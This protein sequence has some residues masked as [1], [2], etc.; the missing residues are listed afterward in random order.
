M[1]VSTDEEVRVYEEE[2]KR[3]NSTLVGINSEISELNT[4][5]DSIAKELER[6]EADLQQIE[7]EFSRTSEIYNQRVVLMYKFSRSGLFNTVFD[8][9]CLNQFYGRLKMFHLL[10]TMD[11]RAF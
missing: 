1:S 9:E 5:I 2:L 11:V 6:L 7:D 8:A 3:A 10:N 4:R